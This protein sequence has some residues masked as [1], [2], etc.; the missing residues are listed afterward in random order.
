MFFSHNFITAIVIV[1]LLFASSALIYANNKRITLSLEKRKIEAVDMDQSQLKLTDKS[2][3]GFAGI[4]KA[5]RTAIAIKFKT[6]NFNGFDYL[7]LRI[8]PEMEISPGSIKVALRNGKKYYKLDN[9]LLLPGKSKLKPGVW[10][11]IIY[12][13]RNKP[14]SK[15]RE[16]RIY[17]NYKKVLTDKQIS[18]KI[19][20]NLDKNR[21]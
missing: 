13:L 4:P 9:A 18:G 19:K 8:K 15:T 1:L 12:D 20:I 6:S 5:A 14:R 3:I 11:E 17:L 21:V 10:H 16:F 2:T 7:S